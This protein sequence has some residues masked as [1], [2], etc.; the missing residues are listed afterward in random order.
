MSHK[1]SVLE[2][3][4][5]LNILTGPN[6]S[7]KSAVISALQLL[8]DLPLKEGDYM[9]RHGANEAEITIQTDAD[10][11]LTWMRAGST[12]SLTINGERFVRLQND[13]EHFLNKLQKVLKLPRVYSKE[14]KESFD[15]HFGTQKDPIFLINEPS[16]RAALFFASSSDAGRLVEVREKYKELVKGKKREQLTIKIEL[17]IQKKF[18]YKLAFLDEMKDKIQFIKETF[19][20]YPQ[21]A[22]AID[23]G[24]AAVE[25]IQ[26]L[27]NR[28]IG[29]SAR[30]QTLIHLK[31]PPKMEDASSLALHLEMMVREKKRAANE[32]KKCIT[33]SHLL[34]TPKLFP[35]DEFDKEL[36]ILKNTFKNVQAQKQ[37]T[38]I[39]NGLE[40]YPK[41]KDNAK[42]GVALESMKE[43]LCTIK[44]QAITLSKLE[45]LYPAPET[46]DTTPLFKYLNEA[47]SLAVRNKQIQAQLKNLEKLNKVPLFENYLE[48]ENHYSSLKR[49]TG[50]HA[51]GSKTTRLLSALKKP[52][53][54]QDLSL[55]KQILNK[56]KV[57]QSHHQNLDRQSKNINSLQPPPRIATTKELYALIKDY[58]LQNEVI[59]KAS[60]ESDSVKSAIQAYVAEYPSCPLC[61]GNLENPIENSCHG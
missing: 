29:H 42:L 59:K 49:L 20:Q 2:L 11:E 25:E 48:L 39:L 44:K 7:G 56:L 35:S 53:N 60:N 18:L 19:R 17:E 58:T 61:G 15:I 37:A 26:L 3:S 38:A 14:T 28:Y 55:L 40:K 22:R 54:I 23:Q 50:I 43:L 46:Q 47:L 33:L 52:P 9:V 36:S 13:R 34:N 10:D 30:N 45:S 6:N 1:N 51:K 12:I 32:T 5:G 21:E 8:A 4:K 41:M 24:T 57:M 16:S 31:N 27:Q